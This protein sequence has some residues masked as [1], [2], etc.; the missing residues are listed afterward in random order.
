MLDLYSLT[1]VCN[2]LIPRL[3][4]FDA[5]GA[6]GAFVVFQVGEHR[7][8]YRYMEVVALIRSYRHKAR[9]HGEAVQVA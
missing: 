5:V 7:R 4:P 2:C 3:I 1:N 8:V 6:G 9:P